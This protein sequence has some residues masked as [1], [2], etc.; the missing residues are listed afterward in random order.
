[1]KIGGVD[2][3][4]NLLLHYMIIREYQDIKNLLF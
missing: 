3:T 1:M 4:K 2:E